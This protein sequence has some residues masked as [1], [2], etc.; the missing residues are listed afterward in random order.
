V[1]TLLATHPISVL[2]M[3]LPATSSTDSVMPST[4][5]LVTL[6]STAAAAAVHISMEQHQQESN[7]QFMQR[8]PNEL[9]HQQTSS[10]TPTMLSYEELRPP[11]QFF[12]S[13]DCTSLIMKA[14]TD[15]SG[16]DIVGTGAFRK[17]ASQKN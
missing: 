3:I 15:E 6:G 5:H 10:T 4:Q 8:S 1:E 12:L 16:K 9:Y 13:H 11:L 7:E 17:I 2:E 14:A